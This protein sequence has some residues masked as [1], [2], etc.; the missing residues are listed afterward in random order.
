MA[1]HAWTTTEPWP[2]HICKHWQSSSSYRLGIQHWQHG[3]DRWVN[4][5]VSHLLPAIS[6]E[7]RQPERHTN[8]TCGSHAQF[9]Y[10][11]ASK[12]STGEVLEISP[13]TNRRTIKE[14]DWLEQDRFS[15]PCGCHGAREMGGGNG[16]LVTFFHSVF[17]RDTRFGLH[18]I[19]RCAN[20]ARAAYLSGTP[21]AGWWSNVG[22]TWGWHAS[23]PRLLCWVVPLT[24]PRK[25]PCFV[26]C[27]NMHKVTKQMPSLTVTSSLYCTLSSA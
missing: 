2:T 25:M 19:C 8:S 6:E 24:L 7:G 15:S 23:A 21:L 18:V 5:P 14:R 1:K 27:M 22:K 10:S 26:S 13:Y 11:G 12:M 20:G 4:R 16:W 9:S 17:E 3:T